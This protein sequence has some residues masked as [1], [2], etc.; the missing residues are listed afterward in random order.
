[1]FDTARH[2]AAQR[3]SRQGKRAARRAALLDTRGSPT[4]GLTRTRAER[5]RYL[6]RLPPPAGRHA[7]VLALVSDEGDR[8]AGLA[9]TIQIVANH[10][11]AP[12]PSECWI[13]AQ[14]QAGSG[15]SPR[16]KRSSTRTTAVRRMEPREA[17]GRCCCL[18]PIAAMAPSWPVRS[19]RGSLSRTAVEAAK[20]TRSPIAPRERPLARRRLAPRH[21]GVALGAS[22]SADS[23][24][25]RSHA[26]GA[27]Q[28]RRAPHRRW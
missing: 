9:R 12:A 4:A 2:G 13:V 22:R 10:K 20:G 26:A 25:D 15:P 11:P 6:C 7:R 3:I 5:A 24:H 19:M 1:M 27:R 14:A 28:P 8:A 23:G 16:S 17:P 18:T 21:R